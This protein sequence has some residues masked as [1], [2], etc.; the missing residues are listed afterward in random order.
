LPPAIAVQN[1][2]LLAKAKR[3]AASLQSALSKRAVIDH[4][5]AR[6]EPRRL[7]RR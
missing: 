1:A 2:Q 5:G 6:D 7:H 4:A 3:V